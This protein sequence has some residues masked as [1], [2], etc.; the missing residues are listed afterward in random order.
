MNVHF[1]YKLSKTPDLE[2]TVNQ[3]IDKLSRRL[4]VFRPEL[5]HLKGTID[6]LPARQGQGFE[7]T[8]NLRLPSGQLTARQQGKDVNALL[9]GCFEDLSR[10]LTTHKDLLRS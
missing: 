3:Q 10:Q 8:L 4:Q 1:S 6:Q 5:I 2:H 7:I 9:K